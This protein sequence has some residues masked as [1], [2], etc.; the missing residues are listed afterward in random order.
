MF[1]RSSSVR[2]PTVETIQTRCAPRLSRKIRRVSIS[3]RRVLPNPRYTDRGALAG[4]YTQNCSPA[5]AV[6]ARAR[7]QAG[8][9]FGFSFCWT[10]SKEVWELNLDYGLHL[11]LD[12][13][14][15]WSHSVQAWDISR[16]VS[17]HF[18]LSVCAPVQGKGGA[19]IRGIRGG[20]GVYIKIHGPSPVAPR[21]T[22]R[23][24]AWAP[25]EPELQRTHA[26]TNKPGA[27]RTGLI[28]RVRLSRSRRPR[29]WPSGPL[30]PRKTGSGSSKSQGKPCRGVASSCR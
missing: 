10:H 3:R 27:S 30:R 15:V 19:T 14:L 21:H 22:Q 24:R 17:T 6:S 11:Y 12:Y 29:E 23:V 16:T 4:R 8:R 9:C 26:L 2:N 18:S 25:R 28:S 13:G 20:S 1:C 5:R 7:R